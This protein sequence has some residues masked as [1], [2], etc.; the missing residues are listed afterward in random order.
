[1]TSIES[2]HEE[3]LHPNLVASTQTGMQNAIHSQLLAEKK[4]KKAKKNAFYRYF[5]KFDEHYMKKIFIY[6]YNPVKAKNKD[7]FIEMFEKEG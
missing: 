4:L 3:F 7:E 2:E 5:E 6:K 1:M